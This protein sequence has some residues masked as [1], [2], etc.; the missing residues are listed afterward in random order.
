MSSGTDNAGR[1]YGSHNIE[2]MLKD[3]LSNAYEDLE[4]V[5]REIGRL[6]EQRNKLVETIEQLRKRGIK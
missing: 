6:I 2:D 1:S 3:F 4:L 5:D